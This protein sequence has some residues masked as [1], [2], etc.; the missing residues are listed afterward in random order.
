MTLRSTPFTV[1]RGKGFHLHA[2]ALEFPP[3]EIFGILGPNGAGKSTLLH[4]LA[5]H[6]P[7]AHSA[8][9]WAGS[10]RASI[11]SRGWARNIAFVAQES[12]TSIDLTVRQ[13]VQLGRYPFNGWLRQQTRTDGYIVDHALDKCGLSL[14]QDHQVSTLSGGQRQRAKIARA[15]AQEPR[16]LLLDEPTNHLD[17]AAI[18]DTI[19]LLRSLA[20]TSVALVVSLH[21]LD[22]ASVFTDRVAIIDNGSVAATGATSEALTQRSIREHWGVDM[23]HTHDQARSRYLLKQN[24]LLRQSV[25]GNEPQPSGPA[26][27]HP[28]ALR[29]PI[30]PLEILS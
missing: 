26:E 1:S 21:D 2:P 24:Y 15:L 30:E 8:V 23:I 13:F 17:L 5:G 29:A 20:S 19:D 3:G 12:P 7:A 6:V 22:L 25:D 16:A 14:L 4:S 10:S 28:G 18:R 9:S 11:G 27:D